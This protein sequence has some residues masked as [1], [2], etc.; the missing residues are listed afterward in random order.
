MT[1]EEIQ[2]EIDAIEDEIEEASEEWVE[3]GNGPSW[4]YLEDLGKQLHA[5]HRE[6]ATLA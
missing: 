6:L 3:T 1:A 5:L 2:A 4:G